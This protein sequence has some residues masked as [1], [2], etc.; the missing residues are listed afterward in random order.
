ME[1]VTCHNE[2]EPNSNFCW[3]CWIVE[4]QNGK[5]QNLIDYDRRHPRK[6]ETR[7]LGPVNEKDEDG[8]PRCQGCGVEWDEDWGTRCPNCS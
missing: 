8:V 3:Q 6:D 5:V 2:P 7:D 4:R 1:C